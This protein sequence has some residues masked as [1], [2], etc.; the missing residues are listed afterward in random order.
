MPDKHTSINSNNPDTLLK[1]LVMLVF[2]NHMC[3]LTEINCSVSFARHY[4]LSIR[5]SNTMFLRNA[6]SYVER[7]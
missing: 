6:V 7:N 4:T 5:R 1:V 2:V 3:S